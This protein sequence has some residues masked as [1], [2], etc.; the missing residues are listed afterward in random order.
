LFTRF[1][2]TDD[3]WR[4]TPAPAQNAFSAL[5]HRLLLL[6][7]RPKAYDRQ[8]SDFRQQVSQIDVLDAELAELRERLGH[9]LN[10]SSKPPSTGPPHLPQKNS[11][12]TKGRARGKQRGQ[13][14]FGRELKPIHQVDHVIDLRPLRCKNCDHLLVGEDAHPCHPWWGNVARRKHAPVS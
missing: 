5:H 11:S 7:S 13:K 6:H 12:E 8:L 4:L 10:N 1:A 2:I 3:D 9:D 14:G